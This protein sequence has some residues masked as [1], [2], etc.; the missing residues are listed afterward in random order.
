[1]PRTPLTLISSNTL[2]RKELTVYKR[3]IIMGKHLEGATLP[4]ISR[5]LSVP[6]QTVRDTILKA[7]SRPNGE[8]ALRSSQPKYYKERDERKIVRFARLSP[9]LKYSDLQ[10][11]S[12]LTF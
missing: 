4:L 2:K 12:G 10:K 7:V 5:S 6:P 11:D 8:S 3:G 1:M 9:F